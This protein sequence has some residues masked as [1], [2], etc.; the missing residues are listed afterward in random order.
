MSGIHMLADVDVDA[1][2]W[3]VEVGDWQRLMLGA[4]RCLMR[5]DL[6]CWRLGAGEFLLWKISRRGTL[7]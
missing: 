4:G 5:E 6:C 1:D 3:R 2:A 7:E